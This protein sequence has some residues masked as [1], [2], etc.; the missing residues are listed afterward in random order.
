MRLSILRNLS[1]KSIIIIAISLV[2]SLIILLTSFFIL[3]SKDTSFYNDINSN[4]A[5]DYSKK[6][7]VYLNYTTSYMQFAKGYSEQYDIFNSTLDDYIKLSSLNNSG[8]FSVVNSLRIHYNVSDIDRKRFE[9]RFSTI[10]NQ[11]VVIN[12]LVNNIQVPSPARPYYCP[13]FFVTPI[14]PTFIF[15]PGFDVC[16]F[17]DINK[18]IDKLIMYPDKIISTPRYST[19]I[20]IVV[21][22]FLQ[23]IPDGF[24]ILTIAIDNI[25]NTILKNNEKIKLSKDDIVFFDGCKGL[26]NN[27]DSIDKNV[28][29]LNSEIIKMSFYFDKNEN[30]SRILFILLAIIIFNILIIIVVI[31]SEIQKNRFIIVDRMIGYVNHEIRNPLNSINGLIELC[32]IKLDNQRE[33]FNA[34][35]IDLKNQELTSN[36]Y[37]AKRACDMLTHI[38][39]DILD[40]K[41][42]KDGKLI[43]YKSNI[44]VKDFVENLRKILIPKLNEVPDVEFIFENSDN[45]SVIYYDE[46]R[47][48]QI[49]LNFLTNSLKFTE[50]GTI[51]LVLEN[52]NTSTIM[53]SVIDTGRGIPKR[54][55][56]NI[57]KPFEQEEIVN[58]LRQGGIGLGLQL[59]KL[60]IDQTGDKIGFSSDIDDGSTF[61]ISIENKKNV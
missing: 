13:F 60:I 49:L 2:V 16:H 4:I 44:I 31:N 56:K 10:L 42:I 40:L 46:Q 39:N 54:H 15:L 19:I 24:I 3:K 58:S 26:C 38:V 8:I 12:D 25:V 30:I 17:G 43:I 50:S 18:E 5:N 9:D 47:L 23:K 33:Q 7:E 59:C 34:Q 32:L 35:K 51:K 11:P 29:L 48:L 14:S 21:F 55:F 57:F 28:V 27:I 37:T 41:R 20:N 36:L 45:I 53:I 22:D 61:W 1:K 6:F 52:I